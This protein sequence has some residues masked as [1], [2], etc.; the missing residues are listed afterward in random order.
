MSPTSGVVTAAGSAA[1]ATLSTVFRAVASVRRGKPL[2]PRGV[3]VHARLHRHGGSR[4]WGSA[5]LDQPGSDDGVVRLSRAVGVP[6]PLP[7]V[8]GLALRL[9]RRDGAV[10]DLLLSTTGLAPVARAVLVPRWNPGAATYSSLFPYR[11]TTGRRVVL[12]AWPLAPLTLPGEP[13][14]LVAE[15]AERPLQLTLA[16]A[17]PMGSWDAFATLEVLAD[18]HEEDVPVSFDPVLNPLP[19]LRLPEWLSH[20]RA[21]AYRGARDGRGA[22]ADEL[23]AVPTRAPSAGAGGRREL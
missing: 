15:L 12:A 6:T 3:V 22:H 2:H 21:A 4:R 18:G 17:T 13:D 9:H 23:T 16:V 7:D 1:G 11:T 19:G 20:V 5:W 8:L 14:V 10:H